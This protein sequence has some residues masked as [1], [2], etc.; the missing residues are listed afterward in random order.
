MNDQFIIDAQLDFYKRGGAGCMFAAHAAKDPAR[1]GWRFTLSDADVHAIGG[2]IESAIA[3]P[4]TSTQ[5]ILIPSADDA[6]GL[7]LLLACLPKTKNVSLE[8][9][10]LFKRSV[11]IGYRIRVGESH[12][13]VTGFGN[14]DFLPRTRRAPTTELA[15][16]VKPRPDFAWTFKESPPGVIH[17]ADMNMCGLQERDLR[18]MWKK[19]FVQVRTIL[20]RKPD[21]RSAAKTTFAVPAVLW[22]EVQLSSN[23]RQ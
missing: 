2:I 21:L 15:F 13:W 19:S 7:V 8:P 12:S 9:P 11:C 6:K 16:R 14:F 4:N 5:S 20:G 17:L 3:D 23:R 10:R 18:V 22:A 1:F